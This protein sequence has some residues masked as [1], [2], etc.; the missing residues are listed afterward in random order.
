V[1]DKP[2]HLEG[3][4]TIVSE[5]AADRQAIVAHDLSLG[6]LACRHAVFNLPYAPDVFL[7]LGLRMRIGGGDRLGGFL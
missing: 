1:E 3:R 7:E 2:G 5:R 6:V 4:L